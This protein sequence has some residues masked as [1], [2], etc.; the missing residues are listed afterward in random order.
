MNYI[1]F[2]PWSLRSF[3]KGL[4]CPRTELTKDQSALTTSAPREIC[5]SYD[6]TRVSFC[7]PVFLSLSTI[8]FI[9]NT[10]KRSNVLSTLELLNTFLLTI[11]STHHKSAYHKHHF[12]EAAFLYI[13]DH[14]INAIGSQKISCLCLLDHSVAFGTIDHNILIIRLSSWF[15]LHGSVLECLSL[16]CLISFFHLKLISPNW[17]QTTTG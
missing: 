6:L 10:A 3:F 15:G 16:T 4:K 1:H 14:L 2:G 8:Y 5:P 13:H 7:K 11:F 12:T 9:V 17:T